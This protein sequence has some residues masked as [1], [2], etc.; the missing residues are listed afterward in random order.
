MSEQTFKQKST[1]PNDSEYKE[2]QT[3][4]DRRT[5]D[6]EGFLASMV[7]F[8]LQVFFRYAIFEIKIMVP[9]P[10]HRLP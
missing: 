9:V 6:G 5:V 2:S 1:L 4:E 7:Q 10:P 8:C 3:E